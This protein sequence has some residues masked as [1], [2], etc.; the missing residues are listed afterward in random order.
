MVDALRGGADPNPGPTVAPEEVR[1]E[2][3][4]LL[5]LRK[6]PDV[7]FVAL[8]RLRGA[9]GSGRAALV[10]PRAAFAAR[11]GRAAAVARDD[12]D[13]RARARAV[14]ERCDALGVQVVPRDA[15]EYPDRL[16][17]LAQPPAVL[18]LKGRSSLLQRSM[19]AVVGSRRST[20]GG[21]R[22][23]AEVARVLAAH[24]VVVAS[25]LALGIDA[26]AHR[27]TLEAGGA[28]L[29]VLGCGIDVPHPP[30]NRGLFRRIGRDGLL[31]TEFDP[32]T[33][34]LPHHFPARNRILAA[35]VRGVLVVEAGARSGA[36]ITEEL[37]S[38]IGRDVMAVPGSVFSDRSRGTNRLL[39]RG[40][41]CLSEPEDVLELAGLSPGDSQ[42]TLRLEPTGLDPDATA[43]WSALE[44]AAPGVDEL[45][46]G[47][48]LTPERALSVLARLELDGW[49][50][51]RPGMRFT[52]RHGP[53]PPP[54]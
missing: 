16:L 23:A 5:V 3:E 47:T 48:G 33:E 9:F 20:G 6:L 51:R 13:R 15:R 52:R 1:E 35:L 37:A 36:L 18:F 24:R 28:T 10:A 31:V 45:A 2:A 43:L 26:A 50:E 41:S 27:A 25:G 54:A 38:E 44:G 8:E 53:V 4:A 21:R 42:A 29:A 22:V 49:V 7:G 39:R 11:A 14:L 46:R 12:P 30:S 19:V 32:G 17:H 40:V 34:P